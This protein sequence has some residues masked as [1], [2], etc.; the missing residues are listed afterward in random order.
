MNILRAGFEILT[1]ISEGGENQPRTKKYNHSG[2]NIV[3][4]TIKEHIL[5]HILLSRIYNDHNMI[6]AEHFMLSNKN[7]NKTN[8]RLATISREKFRLS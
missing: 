1:P 5:A 6:C 3:G 8:L 7:G 2:T 4:L